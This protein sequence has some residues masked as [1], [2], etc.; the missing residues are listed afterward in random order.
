MY[1]RCTKNSNLF[2]ADNPNIKLEPPTQFD[3]E[4]YSPSGCNFGKCKII[5]INLKKKLVARFL[6]ENSLYNMV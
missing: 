6:F 1:K 4:C 2:V 3:H 5:L